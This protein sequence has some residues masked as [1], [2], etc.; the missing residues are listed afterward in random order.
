MSLF[1]EVDRLFTPTMRRT[2]W[3]APTSLG[4]AIDVGENEEGYIVK[5]AV[6][7]VSSDDLDI[8]LEDGVLTIKGEVKA[9]ENIDNDQYHVRERR[10]GSFSRSVRFPVAVNA[11]A[12][13][14]TYENGILTLNIPKAEEVKPK[15]IAVKV[16]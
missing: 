3:A 5:A 8:T 4:L 1:D 12:I 11:E 2:R 13:E 7:G 10:Y 9:D 16:R 14:A 6:P 15:R